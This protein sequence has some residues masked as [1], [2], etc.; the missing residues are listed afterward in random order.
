MALH[1]LQDHTWGEHHMHGLVFITATYVAL[2]IYDRSNQS[3]IWQITACALFGT[4]IGF[5]L[6]D[7]LLH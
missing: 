1:E 4:G 6:V 3:F 2:Q 7:V 5:G